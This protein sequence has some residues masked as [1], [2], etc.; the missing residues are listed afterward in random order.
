VEII[1]RPGETA[2]R[3]TRV[4]ATV[5]W[6]NARVDAPSPPVKF[7]EYI[8]HLDRDSGP[9]TKRSDFLTIIIDML[10]YGYNTVFFATTPVLGI[11]SLKPLP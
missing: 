5:R 10:R 2:G 11:Q 6:L 9:G 7:F 4:G 3:I 8:E 1:G